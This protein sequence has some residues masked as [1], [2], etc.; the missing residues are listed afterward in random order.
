MG[1]NKV[2]IIATIGPASDSKKMIELLISNGVNI[3]RI[4]FSHAGQDYA[5]KIIRNINAA[6]RK[7]KRN[8]AVFIDLPG[9]KIRTG[10]LSNGKLD[11]KQGKRYTLGPGCDIPVSGKVARNIKLTEKVLLSDGKI[12]LKPIKF[13]GEKLIVKALNS[14]TLLDRQSINANGLVYEESY[15]TKKDKDAIKFGLKHGVIAFGLSFVSRKEDVLN[16]RKLTGK[17]S[18]LIAKIERKDAVE[19][20]DDIASVSDVIMIARGD[21]GLNLDVAKVPSIQKKLIATANRMSKPVITATQML[22]SMTKDIM[23]T[24]AEVDDVFTAISEGTDAVMLSEETAIGQH[25]SAAVR[26]LKHIISIYKT[27]NSAVNYPV[28]DERDA[29]IDAAVSLIKKTKIKD[30]IIL[31]KSGISAFRLSRFHLDIRIFAITDSNA[32][33][34]ALEFGRSVIPV[35]TRKLG[36]YP[37]ASIKAIHKRG[38]LEKAI[39]ISG[40]KTSTRA[41]E[42]IRVIKL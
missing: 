11:I 19:N 9:P 4:N 25:P 24:R 17:E 27:N 41:V 32:V 13:D 39:L 1:R 2:K 26:M 20:F 7:L 18:V 38:K 22:E 15:P 8:V 34:C 5:A 14:A 30:I 40:L 37:T 21:L 33:F 28:V 16:V 6:K 36:R 12:E 23:P 31:S 42:G 10:V 29:L 3:F 35:L